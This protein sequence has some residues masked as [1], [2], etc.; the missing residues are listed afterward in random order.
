MVCGEEDAIYPF[1][2]SWANR[3]DKYENISLERTAFI[4]QLTLTNVPS[5][6]LSRKRACIHTV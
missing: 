6:Q 4:L 2:A 3:Q 1:K 5:K